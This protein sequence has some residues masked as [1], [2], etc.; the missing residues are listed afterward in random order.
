MTSVCVQ[1]SGGPV[2]APIL[3]FLG[4]VEAFS[5]LSGSYSLEAAVGNATAATSAYPD[6]H[7]GRHALF[8]T[9]SLVTFQRSQRL[10][11]HP[12]QTFITYFER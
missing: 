2:Q 7:V 4:E 8:R 3:R 9:K 12:I 6:Y 5:V 10:L 1:G 11:V